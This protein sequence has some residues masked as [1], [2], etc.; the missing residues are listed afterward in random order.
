MA[1]AQQVVHNGLVLL[2]SDAA[3]RVDENA[4]RRALRID[5]VNGCKGE[6]L[7]QVGHLDDVGAGLLRLGRRV[8]PDDSESRARRIEQHAVKA[9]NSLGQLRQQQ[10]VGRLE[11]RRRDTSKTRTPA[12]KHKSRVLW[13]GVI[14]MECHQ[15]VV[16]SLRKVRVVI[17][18]TSQAWQAPRAYKKISASGYGW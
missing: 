3:R 15:D 7:L 2:H 5:R 9:A 17:D 1:L 18:S 13:Y 6:L 11:V 10:I 4:P 8:T 12:R 14:V 16:A